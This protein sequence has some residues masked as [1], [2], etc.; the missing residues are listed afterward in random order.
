MNQYVKEGKSI[1][2][3]YRDDICKIGKCVNHPCKG[4]CP[5]LKYTNGN[6]QS[7]EVL[8]SNLINPENQEFRDYKQVIN[9]LAEDKVNKLEPCFERMVEL[10]EGIKDNNVPINCKRKTAITIL[11]VVGYKLIDIEHMFN[12][13]H[14]QLWRYTK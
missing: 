7:K 14:S 9:E 3:I 6:S 4:L 5:L 1:L 12:I 13:S 2:K 8:L 10:V 11:L